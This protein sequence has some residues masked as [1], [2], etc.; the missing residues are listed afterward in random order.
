LSC[1]TWTVSISPIRSHANMRLRYSASELRS[2][3]QEHAVG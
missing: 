2:S 1:L 3:E